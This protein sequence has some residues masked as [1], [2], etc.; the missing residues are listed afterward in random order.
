M[1]IIVLYNFL[2]K[3]VQRFLIISFKSHASRSS[4]SS[5][6]AGSAN[7]FCIISYPYYLVMPTQKKVFKNASSK[8]GN[9]GAPFILAAKC[10]FYC[11]FYTIS[12][13]LCLF[14]NRRTFA[15]SFSIAGFWTNVSETKPSKRMAEFFSRAISNN[16]AKAIF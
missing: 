11:H 4:W 14:G 10:F 6:H 7:T 3:L 1:I 12:W 9:C 15:A 5:P 13:F 16:F 2:N 8:K